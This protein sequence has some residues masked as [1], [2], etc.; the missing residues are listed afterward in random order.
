MLKQ[1]VK[2]LRANKEKIVRTERTNIVRKT[3]GYS[4]MT[5]WDTTI[6]FDEVEV[7]DFEKLLEEID[8]FAKTFKGK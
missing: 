3:V 4:E 6:S 7:V 2:H 1:L 5:Q 8:A